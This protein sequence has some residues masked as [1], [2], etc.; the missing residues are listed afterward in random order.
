[1]TDYGEKTIS[2][3]FPKKYCKLILWSGTDKQ[4]SFRICGVNTDNPYIRVAG[5]KYILTDKEKK[6]LNDML[7]F[8]GD[9]KNE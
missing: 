6:T 4:K 7:A 8:E 3:C 2:I 9:Y 1:M 5:D